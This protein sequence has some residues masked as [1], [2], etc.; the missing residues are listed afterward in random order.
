MGNSFD[1]KISAVLIIQ[2]LKLM[3]EARNLILN[4]NLLQT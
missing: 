3:Y 2:R 4:N 1:W